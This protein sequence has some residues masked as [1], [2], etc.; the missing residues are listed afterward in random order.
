M[1]GVWVT[2]SLKLRQ[3]MGLIL[4]GE[5]GGG[6]DG[7]QSQRQ[8]PVRTALKPQEGR[9]HRQALGGLQERRTACVAPDHL[10]KWW[11]SLS[12]TCITTW[13][14]WRMMYG[15]TCTGEHLCVPLLYDSSLICEGGQ[16]GWPFI[17]ASVSEKNLTLMYPSVDSSGH[18]CTWRYRTFG[19]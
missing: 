7:E 12:K 17:G 13:K 1:T 3:L 14:S 9:G 16:L 19:F 5:E 11:P 4:Y 8:R 6:S 10:I 2:D 15:C 18:G